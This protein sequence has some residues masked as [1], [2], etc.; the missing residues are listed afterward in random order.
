MYPRLLLFCLLL[1]LSQPGRAADIFYGLAVLSQKVD[2]SVT[3]GGTTL[4]SSEDGSG[5]GVFADM[6]YRG[7]Y[8]FN[9]TISYVDYTSFYITSATAAADYLIPVNAT[10]TLFAGLTAGVTGQVYNDASFSDM[11]MSHLVGAQLGGIMVAGDHLML[12][13]GYRQRATNLETD[14][15]N[16][17]AVAKIDKISETYL[18]INILF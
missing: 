16:A 10:F 9:G 3:S 11:A 18:N 12:E 1:T 14:L 5:I 17:S 8:R 4:T 15:T 13:L 6:Y 7:T 2:V